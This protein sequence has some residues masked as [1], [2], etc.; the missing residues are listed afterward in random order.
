MCWGSL[1]PHARL[2]FLENKLTTKT[3]RNA[4]RKQR[5]I[6]QPGSHFQKVESTKLYK[7]CS[8]PD[9]FLIFTKTVHVDQQNSN[10][11]WE[12]LIIYLILGVVSTVLRWAK[13]EF[14]NQYLFYNF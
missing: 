2:F 11:L 8:I 5:T 1:Y 6:F 9:I 3:V 14:Q 13:M 10:F 7:L 12:N 4:G